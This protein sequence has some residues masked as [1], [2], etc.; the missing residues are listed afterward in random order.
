MK[1]KLLAGCLSCMVVIASTATGKVS[2]SGKVSKS[3][4]PAL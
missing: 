1:K 4:Y 2:P 3:Y